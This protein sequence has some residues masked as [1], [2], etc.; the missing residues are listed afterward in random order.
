MRRPWLS[1]LAVAG[2]V[3]LVIAAIAACT[4]FVFAPS[5]DTGKRIDLAPAETSGGGR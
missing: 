5:A 2:G 1:Y 3:V 4:W